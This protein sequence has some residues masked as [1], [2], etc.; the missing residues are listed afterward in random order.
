ME[1]NLKKQ[2]AKRYRTACD[3]GQGLAKRL[4]CWLVGLH[5]CGAEAM[6]KTK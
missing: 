6:S 4:E 2:A 5:I 1:N 3:K